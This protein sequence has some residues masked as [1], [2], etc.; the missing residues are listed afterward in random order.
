MG[1][2]LPLS[3]TMPASPLTGL[4]MP[5]VFRTPVV[6]PVLALLARLLLKLSGWRLMGDVPTAPRYVL[7]AAPHT[8]NWDF[9]LMLI[10]VL[11]AGIDVHWMGKNSLF[12]PPF[13]GLMLWLGGISIDRSQVNKTAAQVIE[14]FRNADEL[15]VLITPEGTRARVERWKTGFYHI[16]YGAAVPIVLGYVDAA[17]K[18]LGFGPAFIPTGDLDKDLAE[19]QAFYRNKVGINRRD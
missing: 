17:T 8:S 19:I 11:K 10:A 4:P 7:I 16:A 18:Q 13:T 2:A 9:A 3:F 5:T 14:R 1:I 6:R 15:V 12:K